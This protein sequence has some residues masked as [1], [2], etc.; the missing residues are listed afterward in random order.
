[1]STPAHAA[2][3]YAAGADGITA[4]DNFLVDFGLANNVAERAIFRARVCVAELM[5]NALEHGKARPDAD[6]FMVSVDWDG[7][8]TLD[9]EFADTSAW[10]DPTRPVALPDRQTVGGRGLLLV[11]RLATSARYH[12][13]GRSNRVHL[14]FLA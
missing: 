5:A 3:E 13:D 12:H 4:V 6:R 1:M 7:V 9:L 2:E 11:Q 10:F 8:A 14:R